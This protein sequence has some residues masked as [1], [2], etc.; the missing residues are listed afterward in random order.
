MKKFIINSKKIAATIYNKNNL[1]LTDVETIA[2][3]LNIYG[4]VLN[5]KI[6]KNS[7]NQT[8]IF[9][10]DKSYS[11]FIKISEVAKVPLQQTLNNSDIAGYQDETGETFTF[12]NEGAPAQKDPSGNSIVD[13]KDSKGNSIKK[14]FNPNQNKQV[15]PINK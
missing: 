11:E 10:L 1:E 8:I 6:I 2:E 7:N 15:T 3:D 4:N 14:Q 5:Y 9:D 12:E 13:V